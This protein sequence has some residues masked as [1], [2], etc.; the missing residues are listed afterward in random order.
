TADPEAYGGLCL[1][2]AARPVLIDGQPLRLRRDPMAAPTRSSGSSSTPRDRSTPSLSTAEQSL[3]QQLRG[4]RLDL[5]REHKL[6]PYVILTD[7][8]LYDIV[9][10]L[11]ASLE[12]LARIPGIGRSKLERYGEAILEQLDRAR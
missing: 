4:W 2:D 12:Q 7:A 11:P 8:T 6:P 1:T 9:R 3:F 5:A 10:L